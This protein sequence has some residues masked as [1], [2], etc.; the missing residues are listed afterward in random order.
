[1][2]KK[3]LYLL[4]IYYWSISNKLS[5]VGNFFHSR[6]KLF[7]YRLYIRKDEFHQSLNIDIEAMLSMNKKQ[8]HNYMEDLGRRRNIAHIREFKT[9]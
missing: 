2:K 6:L 5:F 7:W 8:Q 1:M 4:V 3:L 9:V